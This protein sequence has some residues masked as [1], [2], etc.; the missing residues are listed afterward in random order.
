MQDSAQLSWQDTWR[1]V[2]IK[3]GVHAG[4]MMPLRAPF[5]AV[6]TITS[7][8]VAMEIRNRPM[9]NWYCVTAKQGQSVGIWVPRSGVGRCGSGEVWSSR[10]GQAF[11]DRSGSLEKGCRILHCHNGCIACGCPLLMGS[12]FAP[13][14][15]LVTMCVTWASRGRLIAADQ[16]RA[17]LLLRSNQRSFASETWRGQILQGSCSKSMQVVLLQL[18]VLGHDHLERF[19]PVSLAPEPSDSIKSP[20]K[21][22]RGSK[23]WTRYACKI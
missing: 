22:L 1:R 13:D 6:A 5:K 12:G 16:H 9:L 4:K 19:D 18:G 15:G 2:E 7:S 8:K 10:P 21:D 14:R 3:E 23:S 17:K 11:G 20:Y